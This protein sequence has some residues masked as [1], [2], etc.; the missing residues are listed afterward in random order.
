MSKFIL[1]KFW[2]SD[3]LINLEAI[4][5]IEPYGFFGAYAGD[6]NATGKKDVRS[7][8][9]VDNVKSLHTP[10]TVE[11][12]INIIKEQAWKELKV[13]IDAP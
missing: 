5:L 8:L 11:Q 6:H 12:L 7:V 4:R 9:Y 1:F 13:N 3:Y 2:E 10:Y